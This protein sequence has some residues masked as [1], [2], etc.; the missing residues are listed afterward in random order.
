VADKSTLS[1]SMK[2]RFA[3][4]DVVLALIFIALWLAPMSAVG[5]LK[6]DIRA[7]PV[8]LQNLHRCACLFTNSVR[9]WSTFHI[10]IQTSDDAAW[11]ELDEA[12]YFDMPVFGYRSRFH[13]ILSHAWGKPGERRRTDEVARFIAERFHVQNPTG[14]KLIAIRFA[15]VQHKVDD[16][17]EERGRFVKPRLDAIAPSRIATTGELRFD[18]RPPTTTTTPRQKTPAAQMQR[19]LP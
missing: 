1:A 15:R 12:G 18:G 3:R 19:S 14:P 13:R 8:Y 5:A 16:L 10:Q 6:S 17:A 4:R 11:S 9:Y 2:P 7:Y